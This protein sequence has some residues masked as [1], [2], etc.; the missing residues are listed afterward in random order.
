MPEA[1]VG[2]G[3]NQGD[4]AAAIEE[5]VQSLAVHPDITRVTCSGLY[6]T[7]PVGVQA[8]EAFLNAA[9]A[10]QTSMAPEEL[11]TCC[12][13]IEQQAGRVRLIHWGPRTLDLDLIGYDDLILTTPRLT[14][15]HPAAWYRRF[16]LDPLCEIAPDWVHPERQQTAAQLRTRLTQLPLTF[17]FRGELGQ[18]RTLATG[19]QQAFSPEQLTVLTEADGNIGSIGDTSST[20]NHSPP[21]WELIDPVTDPGK[22]EQASRASRLSARQWSPL[23]LQNLIDVVRSALDQP[24]RVSD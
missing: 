14:L 23:M 6:Q 5:A 11:L 3:G 18:N 13:Q 7:Q 9:I 24:E 22:W 20:S 17:C 21:V 4:V 15:P 12:Q 16:V 19:L 8:G 2:I 10:C 1:Y